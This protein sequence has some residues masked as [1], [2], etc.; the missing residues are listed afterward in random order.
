MRNQNPLFRAEELGLT[1]PH[2]P[3]LK[4]IVRW[5]DGKLGVQVWA[6]DGE[7]YVKA[8]DLK[9]AQQLLD[10]TPERSTR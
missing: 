3:K 6:R 5:P 9:H 8:D 1:D 2:Y 10:L 7:G 4:R